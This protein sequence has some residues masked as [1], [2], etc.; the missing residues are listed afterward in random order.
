MLCPRFMLQ[1]SPS[2]RRG[3]KSAQNLSQG[4]GPY[5]VLEQERDAR[6]EGE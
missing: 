5:G 6:A 3:H 4:L 1:V 2:D